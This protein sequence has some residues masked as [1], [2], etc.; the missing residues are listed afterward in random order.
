M[1]LG[2]GRNGFI[3]DMRCNGWSDEEA[4][5]HL[6]RGLRNG[7]GRFAVESWKE[8]YGGEGSFEQFEPSRFDWGERPN[9]DVPSQDSEAQ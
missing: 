8:A 2:L 4:C 5:P 6:V 1:E 9:G 3:E 7:P